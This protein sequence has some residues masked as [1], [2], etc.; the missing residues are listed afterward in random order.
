LTTDFGQEYEKLRSFITE[1]GKDSVVIAFSG[2]VDSSTQAAICHEILGEKAVAVTAVSPVY[3]QE[4][5]EE[6]KKVA[7]K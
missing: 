1:K 4:E 3:P 6:A 2:G 5:V 7:K